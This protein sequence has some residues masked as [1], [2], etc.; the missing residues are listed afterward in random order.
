[1]TLDYKDHVV[2]Q[3]FKYDNEKKEIESSFM[4]KALDTI[5]AKKG[6]P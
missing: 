2:L 5:D 3:T 4:F 1:M 6:P